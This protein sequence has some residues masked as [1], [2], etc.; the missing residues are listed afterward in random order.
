MTHPKSKES[1]AR[2]YWAVWEDYQEDGEY[3]H[4]VIST[5]SGG[6]L[7]WEDNQFPVVLKKDYDALTERC[8]AAERRVSELEAQVVEYVDRYRQLKKANPEL[9]R[10]D[11]V[12]FGALME[13]RDALRARV[14]ELE[15]EIKSARTIKRAVN[16]KARAHDDGALAYHVL[17]A[18]LARKTEALERAKH[19]IDTADLH[20]EFR[21]NALIEIEQL[22]AA[23][24]GEG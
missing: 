2:V 9:S 11:H 17:R 15:R 24:G 6:N 21:R 18:E 22:E 14:A 7:Y 23:T 4:G 8:K 13:E 1:G 5:D 12:T 19:I 3:A 10:N 20:A 16:D